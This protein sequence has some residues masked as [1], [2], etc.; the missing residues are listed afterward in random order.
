VV[1][2]AQA[3]G[4]GFAAGRAAGC[5]GPA[6]WVDGPAGSGSADG[7]PSK[8]GEPDLAE[9]IE[10]LGTGAKA[11]LQSV[12]DLRLSVG[13]RTFCVQTVRIRAFSSAEIP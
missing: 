12:A 6:G 2:M 4:T 5:C 11:G 8:A 13:L 7:R 9:Q 3:P 1:V 10:G